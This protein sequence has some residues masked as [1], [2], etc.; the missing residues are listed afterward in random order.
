MYKYTTACR[1]VYI[2]TCTYT[3]RYANEEGCVRMVCALYVGEY[4]RDDEANEILL[5][6]LL[7]SCASSFLR[8]WE[9]FGRQ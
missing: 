9:R 8:N 1:R 7:V 6:L 2:S 5:G 4:T 3:Y